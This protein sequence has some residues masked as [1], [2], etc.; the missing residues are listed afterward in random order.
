MFY[1]HSFEKEIKNFKTL[2]AGD[3]CY[4]NYGIYDIDYLGDGKYR[5]SL[6]CRHSRYFVDVTIFNNCITSH[7]CDCDNAQDP[8][9]KHVIATLLKIKYEGDSIV[10]QEEDQNTVCA[11]GIDD[12]EEETGSKADPEIFRLLKKKKKKNIVKGIFLRR[13]ISI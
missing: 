8:M 10:Q 11:L 4:R 12:E 3:Y 1:L 13:I 2:K 9:C 7:K 6:Q 5:S